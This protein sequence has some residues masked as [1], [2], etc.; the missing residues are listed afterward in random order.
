LQQIIS[1]YPVC[2]YVVDGRNSHFIRTIDLA[3]QKVLPGWAAY[4]YP[5]VADFV[6]DGT[7]RVLVPSSCV[8]GLLML[9]GK[10]IWSAPAEV[11]TPIK[12][13]VSGTEAGD[14]FGDGRLHVARLIRG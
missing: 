2:Y 1:L 11:T 9:E 12:A 4:A 3:S 14:F 10:A 13:N 8:Y 5:I 7:K 6:G